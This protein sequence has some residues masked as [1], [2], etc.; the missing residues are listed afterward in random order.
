MTSGNNH[1]VGYI[2]FAV[3]GVVAGGL[4][5]GLV[6]KSLPTILKQMKHMQEEC[7]RAHGFGESQHEEPQT[8][9]TESA[10]AA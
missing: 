8:A 3:A 1:K 9:I 5:M 7:M 2:A 10:N 6:N 4:A